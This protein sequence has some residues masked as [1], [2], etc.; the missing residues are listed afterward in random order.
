MA[1]GAPYDRTELDALLVEDDPG[2]VALVEDYFE[3]FGL[4]GRLHKVPDG[5]AALS[6]L[7]RENGYADAPVPD[8][9]L[10]DLNLP[11]MDGR[12]LLQIVKADDSPWRTIPVIVFTTSAAAEDIAHSYLDGANAYVTKPLELAD[13]QRTLGKIHEFFGVVAARPHA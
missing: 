11:R 13:F 12:Q 6:F 1:A 7:R 10:L 2:D 5:V 8:L 4:P 3:S 9:I